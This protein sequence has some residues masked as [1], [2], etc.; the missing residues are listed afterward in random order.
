MKFLRREKFWGGFGLGCL[1][2]S[3][4]LFRIFLL[5]ETGMAG[6]ILNFFKD[7]RD[8]FVSIGYIVI[9]IGLPF[10]AYQ[11]YESKMQAKSHLSYQIHNDS[12][13]M[14][15]TIDQDIHELL[16]MKERPSYNISENKQYMMNKVISKIFKWFAGICIQ[17]KNERISEEEWYDI[18]NSLCEH[19]KYYQ[20]RKYWEK[21]KD[22]EGVWNEEFKKACEECINNE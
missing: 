3:T 8:L 17:N 18:K 4:V 14:L 6:I 9:T 19:L 12:I 22:K 21:Y 5:G 16:I 20:F 13:E 15:D 2:I 1:F 11:I 10:T 7:W